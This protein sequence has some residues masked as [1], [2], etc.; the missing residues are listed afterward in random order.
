MDVTSPPPGVEVVC[1]LPWVNEQ[2]ID[3]MKKLRVP[4]QERIRGVQQNAKDRTAIV[5]SVLSAIA[6]ELAGQGCTAILAMRQRLEE[7][8][9]PAL[10]AKGSAPSRRL[11]RHG[12]GGISEN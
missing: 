3:R 11:L 5:D 6:A 1:Q 4:V 9:R 7:Q 12:S 8:F 2:L 10:E